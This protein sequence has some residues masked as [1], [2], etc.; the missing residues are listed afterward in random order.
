M[1]VL[2]AALRGSGLDVAAT[3]DGGAWP[4]AHGGGPRLVPAG[5]AEE[6]QAS[7]VARAAPAV[8]LCCWMPPGVDWAHGWA[9]APSVREYVLIGAVPSEHTSGVGA[10]GMWGFA[11]A[12]ARGVESTVPLGWAPHDVP[13]VARW[14]I[15]R[16][17]GFAPFSV[18]TVRSFRRKPWWSL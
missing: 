5:V 18:S 4:R 17:D 10:P 1:G 7:A 2:A 11:G 16:D 12:A 8:V 6:D 15:C 14:C 3:S 13:S 9:A